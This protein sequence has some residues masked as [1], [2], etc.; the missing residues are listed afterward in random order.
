M[1]ALS[2]QAEPA[3]RAIEPQIPQIRQQAQQMAQEIQE[4][5]AVQQVVQENPALNE[6]IIITPRSV[7]AGNSG[8]GTRNR[9]QHQYGAGYSGGNGDGPLIYNP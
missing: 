9:G 6:P 1:N 8:G 7:R 2:Q 3:A 4:N 5:P